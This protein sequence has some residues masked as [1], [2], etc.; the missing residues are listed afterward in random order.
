M[1]GVVLP[2][3]GAESSAPA[4]PDVLTVDEAADFLHLGRQAVYDAVGRGEIPH[5]R[6]GKHIRFSRTGLIQ[7]LAA[8][9]A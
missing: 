9:A 5:R 6:I 8:G 3:D 7:W 4:P 1:A 2:P